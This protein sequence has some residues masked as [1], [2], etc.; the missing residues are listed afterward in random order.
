M[1]STQEMQKALVSRGR[2]RTHASTCVSAHYETGG[3]RGRK[4]GRRGSPISERALNAERER[5][6]ICF[7]LSNAIVIAGKAVW[8]P[9]C[10]E[11]TCIR[12]IINDYRH[13]M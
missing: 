7:R 5:C 4:E 9:R 11:F 6:Y 10:R 3:G 8:I 12:K 13:V 1:I 2:Q